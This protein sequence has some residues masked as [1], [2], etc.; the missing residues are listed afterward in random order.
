[1]DMGWD[2]SAD[3]ENTTVQ[4]ELL[5]Q[6]STNEEGSEATVIGRGELDLNAIFSQPQN[7]E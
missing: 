1:M 4:I 5:D 7:T 2:K 6:S 3:T